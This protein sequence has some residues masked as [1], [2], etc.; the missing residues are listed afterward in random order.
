M[1][2]I[3]KKFKQ[4]YFVEKFYEQSNAIRISIYNWC[5]GKFEVYYSFQL[6]IVT[7]YDA[8]PIQIIFNDD[9]RFWDFNFN[10]FDYI[11]R[12]GPLSLTLLLYLQYEKINFFGHFIEL[13]MKIWHNS[14]NTRHNGEHIEVL[15]SSEIGAKHAYAIL[16][17]SSSSNKWPDF[18]KLLYQT[19]DWTLNECKIYL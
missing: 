16:S 9:L 2:T 5:M 18:W 8:I 15:K 11:F 6:C 1:E 4:F 10:F 12:N 13:K 14:Y 17:K 19:E 3:R 7:Q